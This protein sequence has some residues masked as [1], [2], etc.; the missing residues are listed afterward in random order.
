[1]VSITV[2][3]LQQKQFKVEAES[4]DTVA[5]LKS[6]IEQSQGHPV[7]NQKLVYS[8]KILSDEKTVEECNIK[9]KDF[10]VLMVSKPKAASTSTAAATTSTTPA[11]SSSAVATD[12]TVPPPAPIPAPSEPAQTTTGGGSDATPAATSTANVPAFG[13][14][15]SFLTGEA[16]E[17]SI[18]NM[19]E[20]GFPRDQVIKAMRASFNNPDRAVE[21]LM[22]GIP[23]HLAAETSGP[24]PAAP[25]SAAPAPAPAPAAQPAAPATG[26][27]TG[28]GNVTVVDSTPQNLFQA[29]AQQASGRGAAGG[30]AGGGAPN[31]D[32]SALRNS[33]LFGQ[34]QQMLVALG[35]TQQQAIEA[36]FACGKN[37]ELAANFL[38]EGGFND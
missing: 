30:G 13:D 29:A 35:F 2:K 8:G 7:S 22:T 26:G 10:L 32:L 4:T 5:D 3:T 20:M 38:F 17:S 25:T 12:N 23:E 27:T 15:G 31:L 19:V 24:A 14:L 11:A 34:I 16:R 9:E 33:P 6:K 37:E 21:Y 1:M 18:N 36:Y 28:Q